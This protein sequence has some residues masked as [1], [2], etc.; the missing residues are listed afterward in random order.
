MSSSDNPITH[1]A[2]FK[3]SWSQFE[4]APEDLTDFQRKE[5]ASRIS[6][7]LG[8][9]Y[10]VLNSDQNQG[11]VISDR[12]IAQSV[13]E[14]T[15]RYD[16]YI[17]FEQALEASNITLEQLKEG[18]RHDL[19]VEAVLDRVAAEC[20]E[21]TDAEA[22]LFYYMHPERFQVKERRTAHH[23]LITV[24][25]DFEEN[26]EQ[27]ALKR[28]HEIRERVC[29]KNSRFSEQAQKHSE[30]PT[31][32]HG[33][34]IGHV[35]PGQLYPEIDDVL[36]TMQLGEISEPVLSPIGYHLIYC[37]EI[38]EPRTVPLTEVL[39]KLKDSL[40]D[41]QRSIHQRKWINEQINLQVGMPQLVNS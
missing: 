13:D 1:Y 10:A 16:S 32:M 19:Q 12:L 33:G 4:C 35:E 11:V 17:A 7:Q 30:C 36:F 25:D 27:S 15:S 8:I 26:T 21:V 5:A 29:K 20:E 2:L 40:N 24:N 34:K 22:E 18:I 37:V 39:P 38:E 23:I 3:L 14:I 9:E 6:N 31:A 28:I 41:R